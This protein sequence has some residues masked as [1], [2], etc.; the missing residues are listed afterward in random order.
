MHKVGRLFKLLP[1]LKIR[2]GFAIIRTTSKTCPD[3]EI[4]QTDTKH[5]VPVRKSEVFWI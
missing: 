2:L 5:W 1:V 4:L 3:K